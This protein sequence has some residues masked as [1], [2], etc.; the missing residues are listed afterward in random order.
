M[1]FSV[2]HF[3]PL[4]RPSNLF[5]DNLPWQISHSLYLHIQSLTTASE[6]RL[7]GTVVRA[8]DFYPDIP[9]SNPTTCRR[10]I[11]SAMFHSFVATIMS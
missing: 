6:S 9:G 10:E 11:I 3:F 2:F 7:F 4:F 1:L 8:L 5:F